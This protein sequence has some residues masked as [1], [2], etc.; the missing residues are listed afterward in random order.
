[1]MLSIN[2][3]YGQNCLRAQTASAQ[4][5]MGQ[6]RV[7]GG[8]IGLAIASMILNQQV[9]TNLAEALSVTQLKNLQQSLSTLSSLELSQQA[10]VA[11][12]FSN[13]FNEQMRICTYSSALALIVALFT[14]KRNPACVVECKAKQLALAQPQVE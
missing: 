12:V 7:L 13:S 2:Q 1:M 10:A 6:A 14:W 11:I 9:A 8:N 3:N 4:G 5:A